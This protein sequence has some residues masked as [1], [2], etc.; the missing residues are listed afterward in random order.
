MTLATLAEHAPHAR[1][2]IEPLDRH[3]ADSLKLEQI[4]DC[5]PD[6]IGDQRLTGR[7]A[8]LQP[9]GEVHRAANDAICR[10]EGAPRAARH[11]GAG[12]NADVNRQGD[13]D[14]RAHRIHRA[15]NRPCR[16][17]RTR[18]VV[19]VRHRS[20]EHAHDIVAD[21]P[22]Y[23]A[24]EP[25]DGA[26]HGLEEAPKNAMGLLRIALRSERRVA[27]QIG[28]QDRD[29]TAFAEILGQS[30]ELFR[31]RAGCCRL[32]L[33]HRSAAAAEA[34][35][36]M[37]DEAAVLARRRESRSASAAKTSAFTIL[38]T[39]PRAMIQHGHAATPRKASTENRVRLSLVGYHFS[40]PSHKNCTIHDVLM[41][42]RSGFRL[43]RD[44]RWLDWLLGWSSIVSDRNE[45]GTGDIENCP[46]YSSRR[47]GQH[48]SSAPRRLWNHFST[49]P[50]TVNRQ[51]ARTTATTKIRQAARPH[52]T[53]KDAVIQIVAAVVR[54]CTT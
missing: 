31:G 41:Q 39:A 43:L 46:F 48:C 21:M 6:G 30:C 15:V 28:E 24:A 34:L 7:S 37:V 13:V 29:L 16:Q 44:R 14:F 54:P 42:S 36:R 32:S 27:R 23:R 35:V 8:R 45:S 19:A 47:E 20:A 51:R 25:R 33:E 52:S 49:G 17:R 10:F 22:F 50:P 26:V 53:P 38:G 2:G 4:F 3:L 9:G 18:G 11:H 1:R 12:G 40:L 5:I